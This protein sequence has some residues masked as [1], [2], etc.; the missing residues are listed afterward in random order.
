VPSYRDFLHKLSEEVTV[1]VVCPTRAAFDDFLARV[2][3]TRG[4]LS[5]VIVDHPVTCWSRDRWLALSE[6]NESGST[7]LLSPRGEMGADIWAARKGDQRVGDDLAYILSGQVNSQR[8]SLFFDGGDFVADDS[9]IF[10]TPAVLLRNLQ[11]TVHSRKELLELLTSLLGR[12]VVLLPEAPDHHAGMYMMAVG[13][14]TVLVGDPAAAKLLI[15]DSDDKM[16]ESLCP[17]QGPD[18]RE[19]TIAK[20]DAVAEQ[21]RLAGYRVERIPIIPGLD[22]RT[23][24]TYLN[25]IIDQREGQR[26]VFLPTF[27]FSDLDRQAQE[28]W[29]R[30]G[31]QVRT[32]DCSACYQ[33]FGS[34]RCL[35]NILR[36]G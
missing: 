11:R 14:G 20:F 22:G 32:V 15:L 30:L 26:I 2:G 29:T 5:P 8:S 18:F 12:K 35:V 6:S 34:L 16:L 17:L 36:R 9:T 21:C 19:E 23:Y 28:V 27:G 4:R 7:I 33:H 10:I 24:V 31:Y 1:H 3:T 13:N 25:V